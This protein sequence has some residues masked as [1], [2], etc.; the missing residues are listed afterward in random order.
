MHLGSV[1][2]HL[3]SLPRNPLSSSF[4]LTQQVV[5][6]ISHAPST[7]NADN[8]LQPS[9]LTPVYLWENRQ[10]TLHWGFLSFFFIIYVGFETLHNAG[11]VSDYVVVLVS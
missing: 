5:T 6:F 2:H 4:Q 9:P 11:V 7:L 1:L 3:K 10:K 8:C